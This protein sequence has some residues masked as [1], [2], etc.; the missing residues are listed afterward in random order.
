MTKQRSFAS[1]TEEEINQRYQFRRAAGEGSGRRARREISSIE[2]DT[3][4]ISKLSLPAFRHEAVGT[5]NRPNNLCLATL[6]V[7]KKDAAP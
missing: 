2:V 7:L 5:V 1:L 4:Q 3:E 6:E